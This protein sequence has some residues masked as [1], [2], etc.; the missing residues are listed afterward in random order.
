[1]TKGMVQCGIDEPITLLV[2]ITSKK[3][4]FRRTP[5]VFGISAGFDYSVLIGVLV[6]AICCISEGRTLDG[7][8][9]QIINSFDWL[10]HLVQAIFL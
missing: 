6:T 8:K 10:F 9:G 1:M 5:A 7:V 4:G 2:R 3:Y